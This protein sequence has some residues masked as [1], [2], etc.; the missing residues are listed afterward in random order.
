MLALFDESGDA[1]LNLKAGSSPYF[2]VALV[3]FEDMQ[4]ARSVEERIS[5]LRREL[6]LDPRFEFR[7]NKCRQDFRTRFL[8][9]VAPYEFFYYGVV[10]DKARLRA[11]E[12][13]HKESFYTY[14]SGLVFENA[15]AALT[16]ATVIIDGSGTKEF[17][18]RLQSY[19]K[20]R[21]NDPGQRAIGKVKIQ[22][23]SRNDLLQLADMVAGAI[24]RS[25]GD[26]QDSVEYRRVVSHREKSVQLW[27][28]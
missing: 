8:E 26:K 9:A 28:K 1:G 15:K 11:P 16:E 14:A 12:L 22:D 19:L 17:Q 25:Y 10:I 6:H 4:E 24:Q 27:P 20:R 21:V 23:S 5:L 13:Q 7:F 2:V 18:R 3:V